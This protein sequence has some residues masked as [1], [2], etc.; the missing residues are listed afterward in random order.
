M[1]TAGA[2]THAAFALAAPDLY[3]GFAATSPFAIVRTLWQDAFLPHAAAL[4]LGLAGFEAAVAGLIARG[5]PSERLGLEGAIA[6]HLALLAFGPWYLLWSAPMVAVLVWLLRTAEPRKR[7]RVTRTNR[8][9][10]KRRTHDA[11]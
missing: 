1:F 7:T 5:G 2:A 6:F 4:G 3:D 10:N 9:P 11:P 8:S